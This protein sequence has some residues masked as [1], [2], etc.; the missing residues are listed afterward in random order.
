MR[1]EAPPAAAGG[2]PCPGSIT[3]FWICPLSDQRPRLAGNSGLVPNYSPR[4]ARR[5]ERA[6]APSMPGE[7]GAA[8]T[9]VC[10][11][12]RPVWRGEGW[13]W[14]WAGPSLPTLPKPKSYFLGVIP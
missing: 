7:R 13:T 1:P 12:Q 11:A 14:T 2:A 10:H 6:F 4:P 9:A 5:W 8:G 3:A